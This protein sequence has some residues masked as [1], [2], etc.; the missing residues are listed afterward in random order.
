MKRFWEVDFFRGIAILFMLLF[1]WS[2]TLKFFDIF[3]I[4]NS[5]FYWYIFPRMIAASFIFIAGIALTLN[6]KNRLK[7]GLTIFGLGLMITIVTWIFFPTYYIRFG[8]LHLIG[9]SII[10]AI[11][12][13]KYT[14]LNLIL[15][16]A[17]TLIGMIL[18]NFTFDFS[19]LLWLGFTPANF[20]SFDYFPMIPWFGFMLLGIYFGKI[21]YI[22]GKRNFRIPDYSKTISVKI[23][24]FLGR[25]SLIIYLLHQPLLLLILFFFGYL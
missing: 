23:I 13:M 25:N 19:W 3:S 9:L 20:V 22:N 10:L 4:S 18:Q 11:P 24:D 21:L 7:H 5:S 14:R 17:I 15:G 12:L 2:F 1:N 16:A 8:I 6:V